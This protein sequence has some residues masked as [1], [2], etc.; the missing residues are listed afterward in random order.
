MNCDK[1][2]GCQFEKGLADMNAV[3]RS[4]GKQA[5]VA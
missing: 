1:M 5:A 3:V 2:I 4:E